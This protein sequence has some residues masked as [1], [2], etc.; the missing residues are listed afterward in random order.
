LVIDYQVCSID[1]GMSGGE[2]GE[3]G[4]WRMGQKKEKGEMGSAVSCVLFIT[5]AVLQ[6][7]KK[8]KIYDES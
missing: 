7:A 3:M 6:K 5:F 2:R 8:Q 1:D 4:G